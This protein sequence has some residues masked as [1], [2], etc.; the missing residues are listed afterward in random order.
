MSKTSNQKSGQRQEMRKGE[1]GTS[2]QRLG[3]EMQRLPGRHTVPGSSEL[4]R[5]DVVWSTPYL[6]RLEFKCWFQL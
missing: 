4:D 6:T 1:C 5:Q 3:W 2:G